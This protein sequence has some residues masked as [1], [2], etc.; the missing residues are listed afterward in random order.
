MPGPALANPAP[1]K[2]GFNRAA[3]YT[4]VLACFLILCDYW[5]RVA[6][7][8]PQPCFRGYDDALHYRDFTGLLDGTWPGA[9]P[10]IQS[11]L[12]GLYLGLVR[13]IFDFPV[14]SLVIPHLSHV[15]LITLTCAMTYTI[16]RRLF[17]PE[18]G[19]VAVLG[20]GLYEFVKF[21]AT[22]IETAPLLIF[23]FTAVLYFL[24]QHRRRARPG[25]LV[26]AGVCLGLAVIGR[27]TNGVLVVAAAAGWLVLTTPPGRLAANL[28]LLGRP[29][30][31]VVSPLLVRNSIL[32]G[33]FSPFIIDHGISQLTMGNLPGAPGTYWDRSAE[34]LAP[35]LRFITG[36]PGDWLLLTLRKFRLF[37]TFPWSPARLHELPPFWL[38]FWLG[39]G[40]LFLGYFFK[41]LSA[42]RCLLHLSLALYAAS[43]IL[44]HVEDEYRTPVLPLIFLVVA[45]GLVD[46]AARSGRLV[47]KAGERVRLW[48]SQGAAALLLWS[49]LV[50]GLF[51]WFIPPAGIAHRVDTIHSDSVYGGVRVGQTFQAPCPNLSQVR[52]KM[53]ARGPGG[54]V[55][56]HLTRGA[57]GG[58]EVRAQQL[59]PAGWSGLAYRSINFPPVPDSAG[60][61]YTFYFDTAHL[62]S[63][64]EGLVFAGG[65]H[66][67]AESLNRIDFEPRITGGAFVSLGRLDG[68]LAF[69]AACAAGPVQLAQAAVA[70]LA[71]KTPWPGLAAPLVLPAL[72]LHALLALA[73]GLYLARRAYTGSGQEN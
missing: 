46:L 3:P 10:F 37:F 6:R 35:T 31:L 15:F 65:R 72:A 23:L 43:I 21:T 60:Q 9:Q 66:P 1:L 68:N 16:G 14:D 52:V 28:L 70:R 51:A 64:E 4:A 18:V 71:Q 11:P 27:Q 34:T 73:A 19:L 22:T 48:R 58:P 40:A 29:A 26:A 24:L 2:R 49:L 36:Q 33:Q 17:W 57:A 59:D 54:P 41:S 63:A 44:T 67:L 47:L 20:L 55:T 32:A 38:A 42:R 53:A 5:A 69:S 62:R 45:Y 25:Y 30:L 7:Q 56:F 50:L 12:P 13:A 39:S 8:C 61:T